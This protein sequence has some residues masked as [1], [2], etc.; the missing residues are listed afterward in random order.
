MDKKSS[1]HVTATPLPSS[2]VATPARTTTASPMKRKAGQEQGETT[3]RRAPRQDPVSCESCRRKKLKCN[4]QQPCSSC[5]TRRLVCSYGVSGGE[6]GAG[7][8]QRVPVQ[9]TGTGTGLGSAAGIGVQQ[10][11]G[12]MGAS[13]STSN[14]TSNS[15][16]RGHEVNR[17]PVVGVVAR[18]ADG[19][20]SRDRN[21]SLET[22]DW[23]EKIVMGDRV[24]TGLTSMAGG[25]LTGP[26]VQDVVSPRQ[27]ST[28]TTVGVSGMSGE[29]TASQDNPAT[30]QLGSYLPKKTEAMALFHYY[31]GCIDYLYHIILPRRVE[32]QIH[33]VYQAVEKGEPVDLS[34]LAL[35]FSIVASALFLQL[36]IESS[37]FAGACSREYTFLTGA[38]LIQGNYSVYP[39]IEGLQATLIVAHNMTSMNIH[40]SVNSLFS[41]G[42]IV[43]QAKT[44]MLH[45]IDSPRFREARKVNGCDLMDIELRRRLWW[46][47]VTYD[48]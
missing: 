24:T 14:S 3:P 21:E 35:L 1:K 17:W 27:G 11:D 16:S 6:G 48:W 44:L 25:A 20:T 10:D 4:R 12:L 40:P 22:A 39:T 29:W 43:T 2:A 15:S 8:Q 42:S 13:N 37:E 28:M 45:C 38:A 9:T 5:V 36:S 19:Q 41:L 7:V 32:E 31:T 18:P 46:D 34:H 33:R 26:K 47:L 23:L 30:V